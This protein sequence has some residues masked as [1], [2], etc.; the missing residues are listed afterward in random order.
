MNINCNC[1]KTGGC[2][3]CRETTKP[4]SN[5]DSSVKSQRRSYPSSSKEATAKSRAKY[6]EAN[7]WVRKYYSSKTRSYP[8]KN[9]TVREHTLTIA[10]IKELWFRDNAGELKKPSI[11]RIDPTKGYVK[12]NCR[13]IELSENQSRANKGIP[14]PAHIRKLTFE[15]AR[16]IKQK[17][18]EKIPVYLLAREYK[19][20]V[21]NIKNIRDN[22]TYKYVKL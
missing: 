6:L 7:P 3:E 20:S 17:L 18:V 14:K 8:C 21:A 16:E 5:E 9:W 11:D 13:F 19:V 22:I 10:Q 1:G 12:E 2:S 4:H 15:Q